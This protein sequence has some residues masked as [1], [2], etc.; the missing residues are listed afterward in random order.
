MAGL[1]LAVAVLVVISACCI[2][3]VILVDSMPCE[4]TFS[5]FPTFTANWLVE[6][7]VIHFTVTGSDSNNQIWIALG[8]VE[9]TE[10][11]FMVSLENVQHC[12][13][14]S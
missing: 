2:P 8:F 5:P 7:S 3:S 1:Q 11:P 10:S 14:Y 4:G 12:I 6:G 13:M 9:Q